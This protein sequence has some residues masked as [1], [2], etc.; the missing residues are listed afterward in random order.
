MFRR[1]SYENYADVYSQAKTT[2]IYVRDA[3]LRT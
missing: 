3:L 2:K 1:G